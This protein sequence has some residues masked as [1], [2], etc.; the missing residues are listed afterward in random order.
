MDTSLQKSTCARFVTSQATTQVVCLLLLFA[1]L[2]FHCPVQA[3]SQHLSEESL[4][5]KRS[6]RE[7]FSADST[8]EHSPQHI[9]RFGLRPADLM[10]GLYLGYGVLGSVTASMLPTPPANAGSWLHSFSGGA[11]FGASVDYALS[12][13]IMLQ[14]RMGFQFPNQSYTYTRPHAARRPF[15]I[16]D[17]TYTLFARI[18]AFTVEPA[19][20]LRVLPRL[21]LVAG[22]VSQIPFASNASQTTTVGNAS[23]VRVI[24]TDERGSLPRHSVQFSPFVGIDGVLPLNINLDGFNHLLLIPYGRFYFGPVEQSF[25]YGSPIQ[26]VQIGISVKYRLL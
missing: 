10:V 5:Y 23:P 20:M 7:I 22:V 18:S 12:D 11:A 13:N 16:P 24:A 1:A 8:G 4:L 21:W 3:S 9:K 6:A 17:T 26:Q 19:V 15:G 14:T 25:F 2:F